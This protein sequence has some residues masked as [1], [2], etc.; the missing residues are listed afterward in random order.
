M[1]LILMGLLASYLLGYTPLLI[2]AI[3]CVLGLFT[4]FL[5]ARDKRA[6]QNGDWRIPESTLH[7]FSLLS[8]WPGAIIAQRKFRHK[9]KKASFRIVFWITV[10]INGAGFAW[11]HSDEGASDFRMFTSKLEQLILSGVTSSDIRES[12]LYFLKF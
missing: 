12:L 9:T 6:A 5:Y 8:G 4:F 11:I 10:I 3:Y 1:I 2:P 7:T